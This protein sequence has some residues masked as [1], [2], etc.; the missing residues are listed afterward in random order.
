[1]TTQNLLTLIERYDLYPNVRKKEPREVLLKTMRDD[2]NMHMISA[3]VTHPR[4]GHPT[5]ATIAFSVSYKNHSPELALKVANELASLYLNENLTHRTQLAEQT[6]SFFAEEAARQ[7]AQIAE[8]DK[9]L[10]AFKERHHDE[11]PAERLTSQ[12]FAANSI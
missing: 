9:K 5:Q 3:D 12:Q 8:L 6:S 2:I 4:S 7:A 1:M 11:L 10:A